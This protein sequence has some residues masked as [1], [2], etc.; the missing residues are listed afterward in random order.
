MIQKLSRQKNF[1]QGYKFYNDAYTK[2]TQSTKNNADYA[3]GNVI[4]L[5][6][7]NETESWIEALKKAAV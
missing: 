1:W 5:M 4:R 3:K 7:S 2:G 6:E